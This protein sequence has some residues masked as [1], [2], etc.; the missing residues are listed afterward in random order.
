MSAAASKQALYRLR[1]DRGEAV[2]RVPVNLN[3]VSNLL[4]HLGL[5]A[6]RDRDDPDAI[7]RA[8]ARQVEILASELERRY[9]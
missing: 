3:R 8:L 4:E 7:A 5:L 2:L 9:R 6:A 1:Q